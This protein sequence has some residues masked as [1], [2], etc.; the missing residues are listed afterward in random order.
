MDTATNRKGS[1]RRRN[2]CLALCVTTEAKN[3][4]HSAATA[5]ISFISKS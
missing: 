4:F 2:C 1:S 3:A 5:R